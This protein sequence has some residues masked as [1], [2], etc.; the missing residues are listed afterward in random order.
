MIQPSKKS[1]TSKDNV[2]YVYTRKPKSE[3]VALTL[4]QKTGV[5]IDFD[6][7]GGIQG[8]EF[9]EVYEIWVNGIKIWREK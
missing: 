5:N 4:R 9:L 2:A 3:K 1:I 8:V 6:D 7:Y